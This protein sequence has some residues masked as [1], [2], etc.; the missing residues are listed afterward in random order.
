MQFLT[1]IG[2]SKDALGWLPWL[3]DFRTFKWINSVKYPEI[4]M[5]QVKELLFIVG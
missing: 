5:K 3:D 2:L 1:H 4:M